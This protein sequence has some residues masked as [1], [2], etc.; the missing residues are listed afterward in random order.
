MEKRNNIGNEKRSVGKGEKS[1]LIHIYLLA[2]FLYPGMGKRY[3]GLPK[4]SNFIKFSRIGP[5]LPSS[6][7]IDFQKDGGKECIGLSI[8]YRSY[9][10]SQALRIGDCQGKYLKQCLVVTVKHGG[11]SVMVWGGICI[12]GVTPLK[13]IVGIMDKKMYHNILVR[14]ALPEGKKLNGKGF[15]FQEDNDLKHASKLPKLLF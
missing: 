14:Q 8:N 5:N 2:M 9:V 7:S 3:P 10:I 13:R 11:G 4:L 15:V 1:L 6:Q 12:N